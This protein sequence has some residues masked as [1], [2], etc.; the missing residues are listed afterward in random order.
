[1]TDEEIKT[2]VFICHCGGNIS[3]VVDCAAVVEM[4]KNLPKV[5]HAEEYIF[6]CSDAGQA[7]IKN[8]IDE[9]GLNRVVVAA[10]PPSL[11]EMTFKKVLESKDVNPYYFEQANIR[12][13]CS[14]IH[15]NNPKEATKKSSGLVS[16][17]VAK[18]NIQME[19]FSTHID[20]VVHSLVIGGGVSGLRAA[21]DI[22]RRNIQVT[23]IEKT[24]IL[25]GRMNDLDTLYPT[26]DKAK[27]LIG[28]LI[29][30]VK[31]DN[32]ITVLT[33]TEMTNFEGVVGDYKIELTS[34]DPPS[35]REVNIGAVVLATGFK[36]YEP[37]EGEYLYKKS[38]NV[39]TLPDFIKYMENN[40]SENGYLMWEGKP[41][42][43]TAFIHCVGSREEEIGHQKERM[44]AYCSRVCC[45][46]IMHTAA[47]LKEKCP[48]TYLYSIFRDIRTYGHNHEAYNEVASETD[49]LFVRYNLRNLPQVTKSD[50]FPF[51]IQVKDQLLDH[52]E[53]E[54]FVDLIV[55]GVGIEP[56]AIDDI[57]ELTRV[58]RGTDGFLKEIHP[59][60]RPVETSVDG[61]LLAGTAQ[62]PL[63]STEATIHASAAAAKVAVI[64]AKGVSISG[65]IAEIDSEEC[66]GCGICIK[67]C[68]YEAISFEDKPEISTAHPVAVLAELLCK[69]CGTCVSA[70]PSGII[71]AKGYTDEQINA[72]IDAIF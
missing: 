41:V 56:E 16:S 70:C 54:I 6:M 57:V 24:A 50:E 72:Q 48:E 68:P 46:S 63:T 43:R 52:L 44:N 22:A 25:G 9:K 7:L 59:K 13:H 5:V 39:V 28:E 27:E 29:K 47:E 69:G 4:A 35:T 32:R 65:E 26:G 67:I 20:P 33:N 21:K 30:E 49:M 62:A 45:T 3:D 51:K 55:L 19:L 18:I 2:G 14:W 11:H 34:S 10:C 66:H 12:E 60:L 42:R 17:A 36:P 31:T 64:M 61:I 23:L 53:L 8:A 71:T 37:P 58:S 40:E 15:K 38:P 1:M